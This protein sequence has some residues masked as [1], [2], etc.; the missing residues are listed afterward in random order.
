VRYTFRKYERLTSKTLIDKVFNEGKTFFSHPFKISFLENETSQDPPV[1]VLIS[2]SKRNFSS[3][4]RRNRI[5]RLIREAYRKNRHIL[6][7]NN[8][9][10]PQNQLVISIVYVAKTIE[11]YSEIERKL[12]L[13]LHR[14]IDKDERSIR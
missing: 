9:D 4:V 2:V 6:W 13:I 1:M 8:K 3:A 7:G 11:T 14:L 5:K 10:N 12:I